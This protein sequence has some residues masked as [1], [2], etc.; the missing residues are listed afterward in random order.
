MAAIVDP[1]GRS[2]GDGSGPSGSY[3]RVGSSAAS[4]ARAFG[5]R[6]HDHIGGWW[7]L[8]FDGVGQPDRAGASGGDDRM[9]AERGDGATARLHR[10]LC[11]RYSLSRRPQPSA[12]STATTRPATNTTLRSDRSGA[13]AST[14]SDERFGALG[15]D[16]LADVAVELVEHARGRRSPSRRRL[17]AQADSDRLVPVARVVE[18]ADL[19]VAVDVALVRVDGTVGQRL[20][21]AELTIEHL[22]HDVVLD[23][24]IGLVGGSVAAVDQGQRLLGSR[25]VA[26]GSGLGGVVGA[27]QLRADGTVGIADRAGLHAAADHQQQEQHRRRPWRSAR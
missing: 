23:L 27:G 14:S 2:S 20:V 25:L 12:A 5:C 6:R 13:T 22:Q 8:A 7:R 17:L 4:A 1:G 3:E 19:D 16:D 18:R 24:P 10:G 9:H 26:G 11:H 15:D 21:P